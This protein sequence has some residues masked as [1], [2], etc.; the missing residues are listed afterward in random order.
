[1]R[2]LAVKAKAEETFKWQ[3]PVYAL[4]G[5]NV[6]WIS[7]FKNHFSIGFFNGMFLRDPEKILVNA[8]EGKTRAMRHL[9]FEAVSDIDSITVLAYMHEVLLNQEKGIQLLPNKG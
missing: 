9:K 5:K 8:Q 4:N 3:S 2:D 6:F 1:M 7:R